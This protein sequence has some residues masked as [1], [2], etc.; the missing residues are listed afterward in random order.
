MNNKLENLKKEYPGL[1]DKNFIFECDNG[2]YELIKLVCIAMNN[3]KNTYIKYLKFVQIK[4]KF[5]LLR[6]YTR[7]KYCD[8]L[9]KVYEVKEHSLQYFISSIEEFSSIVCEKCGQIKTNKREVGIKL[10]NG[11]WKKTLCDKC[12]NKER[13]KCF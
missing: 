10:I 9:N 12:Y 6:I 1:F 13:K 2:W 11:W 5:G 7:S 8:V 3:H 4:E